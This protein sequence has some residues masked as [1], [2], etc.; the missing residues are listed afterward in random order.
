[1][2]DEFGNYIVRGYNTPT[3]TTN[4]QIIQAYENRYAQLSENDRDKQIQGMRLLY[5]SSIFFPPGVRS[6]LEH[7]ADP[8]FTQYGHGDHAHAMDI[9]VNKRHGHTTERLEIVKMLLEHGFMFRYTNTFN[10]ILFDD[11]THN[12]H[13]LFTLEK[14]LLKSANFTE[15]AM[16]DDD[17]YSSDPDELPGIAEIKTAI[18]TMV[19]NTL[20]ISKQDIMQSTI[21]ST[22]KKICLKVFD[23]MHLKRQMQTSRNLDTLQSGI[24]NRINPF[25]AQGTR[26]SIMDYAANAP[27]LSKEQ[28][29]MLMEDKPRGG[30][31]LR[32]AHKKTKRRQ[33]KRSN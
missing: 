20:H 28:R 7:G 23:K 26:D 33:T 15:Q 3:I 16:D 29:S 13:A 18:A 22:D 21:N 27:Y 9:V 2:A 1:M 17:L 30:K 12:N 11:D 5:Y 6:A 8:Y 24:R 31:R 32:S 19:I 14:L 10:M 25:H 4:P